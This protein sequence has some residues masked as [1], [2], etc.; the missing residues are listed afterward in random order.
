MKPALVVVQG[1]LLGCFATAAASRAQSV[2][3]PDRPADARPPV[4]SGADRAAF[5]R[6]H[7]GLVM[8]VHDAVL[9]GDLDTARKQART[10]ADSPD[11]KGLPD[12]AA[13]YI[14]VM[15][16][17]AGRAASED[18]L[19]DVSSATAAMLAACGDCHRAVGTMPATPV[20][21]SPEVG[22]AVGHMLTHK[23]AIDLM[24][25]GLVIPS[26]TAWAEGARTL[27]SA[28]LHRRDLPRDPKLTQAILEFEAD[29]HELAEDAAKASDTR[30]RIYVYSELI[31]SC[32][33]CHSLHP[34]V[35]GPGRP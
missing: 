9:R 19:D 16:R 6:Q 12:A 10:L 2:G 32:G 31:Q 26:T 13:P 35:W 28:P 30:S 7:F 27:Q 23:R 14:V 11:P 22:G 29:V 24:L 18:E 17:A 21:T 3:A 20:P 34:N 15:H 4:R 33:E 8:D 25:Q 5:M 1:V